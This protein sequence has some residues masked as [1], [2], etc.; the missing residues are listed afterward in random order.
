LTRSS[1]TDTV[2]SP[3]KIAYKVCPE[4]SR[5]FQDPENGTC[6]EDGTALLSVMEEQDPMLKTVLDGRFEVLE[7]IGGGGFATVYRATQHPLGRSVAVK[8]LHAR[9]NSDE[10]QLTRFAREARAI[11]RLKSPHTVELHDFG[12]ANDGSPYLVMELI[13]GRTLH[14][15]M[16]QDGPLHPTRAALIGSHVAESL[17]EA[18]GLGIFHRDLKPDNIMVQEIAGEEVARVLDFGLARIQGA[19]L[20]VTGTGVLAGTPAYMS[21]EQAMGEP[22]GAASDLYSLGVIL[23]EALSG[24]QPWRRETTTATL[25]RHVDGDVPDISELVPE[26]SLPFANLI[27][28]LTKRESSQRPE[29]ARDVRRG[30]RELAGDPVSVSAIS[31]PIEAVVSA[32]PEWPVR[33]WLL[34]GIAAACGALVAAVV[35]GSVGA[36]LTPPRE[37]AVTTVDSSVA[38]SWS[39]ALSRSS[40][41]ASPA[42]ELPAPEPPAQP[43]AVLRPP[44]APAAAAASP[45]T[46][47]PRR[48]SEAF[49]RVTRRDSVLWDDVQPWTVSLVVTGTHGAVVSLAGQPLGTIPLVTRIPWSAHDTDLLIEASGRLTR[50]VQIVPQN[51]V[52]L[53]VELARRGRSSRRRGSLSDLMPVGTP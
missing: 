19:N 20:T 13:E 10:R 32:P 8:V 53:P 25:R 40:V 39:G 36:E 50:T 37:A 22:A 16:K 26:L 23:Y 44:A 31:L 34:G 46:L 35:M 5:R 29:S 42:L 17:A 28:S 52:H 6:P 48:S 14:Q 38:A 33:P 1:R 27:R 49:G 43:P 24:T 45:P 12:Q 41:P 21:P 15:L 11:C 30:L 47:A 4:C 51:D 2:S 7:R 18:H 9:L 3:V